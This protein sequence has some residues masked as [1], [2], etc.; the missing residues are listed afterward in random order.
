M[1]ERYG[2]GGD[3][4]TA[5]ELYGAEDGPKTFVDFSANM[6]PFGPPA[7]VGHIL[8]SYADAGEIARYPDPAVRG[9][10]GKLAARHG[11][12]ADGLLVGNGAAELIDLLFRALKPKTTVLAEPCFGEYR[13]AAEKNGSAVRA[14][15]LRAEDGFR[16]TGEAVDRMLRQLREAG[17]A[18]GETLWMLGS[19]NNPT[20]ECV[21]RNVVEKLL[22]SGAMAAV[23]EAFMDFAANEPE[24]SLLKEAASR[25]RLIV[26]RSMTKFYAVPGIRLGY[27]AASP[28]LIRRLAALQ[29]PWSVNS[30]AQRIGEAVLDEAAY[31]ARTVA[32]AREERAWLAARLTELGLT[33][34]GGAA[35]N[36]VLA[37][38][39]GRIGWTSDRLQEELG[40]LGILIRDASRFGAL[41]KR[42]FRVAVRLREDNETL[43]AAL[44]ALL[45]RPMPERE[46]KEV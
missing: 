44:R 3:W 22:A 7:C 20:G 8:K 14:I 9:L 29:V 41:D 46:A 40:R 28:A 34:Y 25:D 2:H 5:R 13:E 38:I 17:L 26:I 45:A 43:L 36:Y 39:P 30:L 19:P 11:V 35:V 23:D 6:N 10:R 31:A 37:A 15:G 21:A 33:A 32:W 27:M 4:V 42:Y 1:L 16:L 18:P 24:L 12:R